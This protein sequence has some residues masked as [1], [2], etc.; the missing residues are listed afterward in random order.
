VEQ[1]ERSRRRTNHSHKTTPGGR[2]FRTSTGA[3]TNPNHGSWN[4]GSDTKALQQTKWVFVF[5]VHR[6]EWGLAAPKPP[7]H[8]CPHP[9]MGVGATPRRVA[10]GQG[11]LSTAR[12]LNL[13]FLVS[14]QNAEEEKNFDYEIKESVHDLSNHFFEF[15]V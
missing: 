13:S 14:T 11:G 12:N 6:V 3:S 5:S 1:D 15:Q 4:G 10:P 7:H 9:L 8:E 2:E